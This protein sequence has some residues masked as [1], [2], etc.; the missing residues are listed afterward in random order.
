MIEPDS[1]STKLTLQRGL[2]LTAR[3]LRLMIGVGDYNAYLVHMQSHHPET[4]A[5]DYAA[6][7]RNRVD[8]RYGSGDGKLKR[9]P[10]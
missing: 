7:Y 10:C 6:W 1:T 8:A 3:T 9:C 5:M 2:S 4:P